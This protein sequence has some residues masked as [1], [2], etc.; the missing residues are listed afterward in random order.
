LYKRTLRRRDFTYDDLIFPKVPQKL[1]ILLSPE[2][3]DRCRTQPPV[4][5]I[6]VLLYAT[7]IRRTEAARIKVG[8]RQQAHG[9]SHSPGQGCARRDVPLS[10]KLL[11][12]LRS[13][14]QWKKPRGY[15][16]PSTAG[17]RRVDQSISDKTIWN[18]CR[19][20]A[21][22]AGLAKKSAHSLRG[23]RMRPHA[24]PLPLNRRVPAFFSRSRCSVEFSRLVRR[25]R[26]LFRLQ[27]RL[28]DP[29]AT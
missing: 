13:Y 15:L 21:T 9:D 29:L 1:P 7:G 22:R 11:E 16:F 25:C 10:P 14:W 4:L 20:A 2:E 8:H 24:G 27:Q 6:L 12:K 5:V 19:V 26:D 28:L 23:T 18:A 3:A 17:Q